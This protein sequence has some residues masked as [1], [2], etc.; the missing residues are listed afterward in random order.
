MENIEFDKI[1]SSDDFDSYIDE[2][3]ESK[4]DLQ[5]LYDKYSYKDYYLVL[6]GLNNNEQQL[7]SDLQYCP[8][9]QLEERANIYVKFRKLLEDAR[10]ILYL[11]EL[12]HQL[13]SSLEKAL[14]I[15]LNNLLI[16]TNNFDSLLRYRNKIIKINQL[17]SIE[18]SDSDKNQINIIFDSINNKITE[19]GKK[20][21]E[22]ST[23]I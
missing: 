9:Y 8:L 5:R 11:K 1:L 20:F 18:I 14:N 12:I 4:D 7:I 10:T 6:R 21:V 15:D 23:K 17:K 3:L 22:L 19:I 2:K 13:P 16:V